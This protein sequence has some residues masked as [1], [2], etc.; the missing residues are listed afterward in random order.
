MKGR[1]MG[2]RIAAIL[3]AI[4]MSISMVGFQTGIVRAETDEEIP[5]AE[6][7]AVVDETPAEETPTEGE[8]IG[9]EETTDEETTDEETTDEETTGGETNGEETTG[10]VTDDDK[11]IDDETT[12]DVTDDEETTDEEISD[13]EELT[14]GELAAKQAAEEEARLAAEEEARLAAEKEAARIREELLATS[15]EIIA[16]Q[17][18]D[19]VTVY[20][21]APEGAFPGGTHVV[22]T[23]VHQTN[24]LADAIDSVETTEDLVA[25]DITFYDIDGNEIQPRDGYTVNVSF[26]LTAASELA[27][28]DATL[29]VYHVDDAQNATPVGDEIPSSSD[30]VEVSVEAESFSVYAVV[31]TQSDNKGKITGSITDGVGEIQVNAPNGFNQKWAFIAK[32]GTDVSSESKNKFFFWNAENGKAGIKGKDQDGKEWWIEATGKKEGVF[33]WVDAGG[34]TS[35]VAVAASVN[36]PAGDYTLQ[37]SYVPLGSFKSKTI[38]YTITIYATAHDVTFDPNGGSLKETTQT[39]NQGEKA[40]EWIPT[41]EGYVFL[42]WYDGK[43]KYDFST[44]VTADLT[45]T[46]KWGKNHNAEFYLLKNVNVIPLENGST[47]YTAQNYTAKDLENMVG[48]VSGT[49]F[50]V[51]GDKIDVTGLNIAKAFRPVQ[52]VISD[53]PTDKYLETLK[54]QILKNQGYTENFENYEILWYVVKKAGGTYHVDGV[55]YDKTAN[56]KTLTYDANT[57]DSVTVPD[58]MAYPLGSE[59]SVANQTPSRAGYTF[60]GWNTQADGTGTSYKAGETLKLDVD[61]TLYAQWKKNTKTDVNFYIQLDGKV[62]DIDGDIDRRPVNFFSG[63]VAR[64]TMNADVPTSFAYAGDKDHAADADRTI[65]STYLGK[66]A[67]VKDCPDDESVFEKLRTDGKTL[68]YFNDEDFIQ[69]LTVDN[70]EIYW[71]VVK[72]DTADGWHVD[73]ILQEKSQNPDGDNPDGNNPGGGTPGGGNPGGGNP[74]GD[75]PS[76]GTPGGGTPGGGNSGGNNPGGDNP[77]GGN[78]GGGNSGGGTAPTSGPGTIEIP[79]ADT[80]LAPKPGDDSNNDDGNVPSDHDDSDEITEIEDED[81]PITDG[82]DIDDEDAPLSDISDEDDDADITSIDDEDTPLSDNPLT[83]DSDSVLWVVMAALAAFGITAAAVTG[84]RK[85]EE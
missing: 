37:Y 1:E 71:Y 50:V 11:T 67:Y 31:I 59:V 72:Y 29:Q 14:T 15:P 25:F 46:A 51:L 9:D 79:E 21:N 84:K 53:K 82:T 76:G 47:Q 56:Y 81:V 8:S 68:K 27:R 45:L 58:R 42:G 35:E 33:G 18:N 6:M 43:N 5:V 48:V 83:G 28:D 26:E 4:T 44:P 65:R 63:S 16:Q 23:P 80:P 24:A 55:V 3:L 70:Y 13:D 77:G 40:T 20:V 54:E 17:T 7:P 69:T 85:R 73:G 66:D 75:N 57:A 19:T 74:G 2:K 30:G 60:T 12:S 61:T 78:P 49:A 62:M 52:E 22:I 41:R 34:W 36:V 64:S 39:V 38:D 32:D 10:D